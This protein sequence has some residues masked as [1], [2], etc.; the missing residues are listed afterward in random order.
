MRI[1][2]GAADAGGEHHPDGAARGE[3]AAARVVLGSLF[4]RKTR[5]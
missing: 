2:K 3:A 1:L 4:G 5:T